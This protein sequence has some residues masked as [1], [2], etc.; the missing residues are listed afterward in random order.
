M[1][2]DFRAVE[3]QR[4]AFLADK[5]EELRTALRSR[6]PN[7]IAARSG[8][9][10]SEIDHARGEVRVPF[11]GVDHVLSFPELTAESLSTFQQALL[12][13]YLLTADGTPASGK[14]VSFADLPDG[15]MYV[16]AFQGYTGDEAVRHFGNS[17]DA[18]RRACLE[19][20]GAP[21]EI[22]DASYVFQALPRVS[23]MVTYWLGDDEF[24]SS[25]KILFDSSASHYLP[26]D[27]S[28]L[29]GSALISHIMKASKK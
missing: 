29:L 8:S 13:Y 24:P 15:R 2:Q 21:V 16:R 14:W 1:K 28:A 19:C 6:D 10:Y 26:I 11:W 4:E 20:G 17:L 27:A 12:F 5:V 3:T 7:Q 22:G 9:S 23:L 25:C 18:F